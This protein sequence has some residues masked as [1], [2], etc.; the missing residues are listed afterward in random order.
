MAKIVLSE[1]APQEPVRFGLSSVDFDLKPGGSFETEDR[2][3]IGDAEAHPWLSVEYDEALQ[4]EPTF[5]DAHVRAE[6]DPLRAENSRA[7]DPEQIKADAPEEEA[8]RPLAV[9]APRDQSEAEVEGGVAV[10]LE[11]DETGEAEQ[12]KRRST[13]RKTEDND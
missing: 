5:R 4:I 8:V 3:A 2:Q 7:F 9:D 12:P 6:D 13:R 10:T 1:A 11:A